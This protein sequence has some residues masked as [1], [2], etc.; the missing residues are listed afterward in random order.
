LGQSEEPDL[1][2]L[3]GQFLGCFLETNEHCVGSALF[4]KVK[5]DYVMAWMHDLVVEPHLRETGCFNLI[6]HS[7]SVL[8]YI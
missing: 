8:Q 7:L 6:F 1:L 2:I 4:L 5:V 3:G